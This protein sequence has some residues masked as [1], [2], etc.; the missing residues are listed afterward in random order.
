MNRSAVKTFGENTFASMN[1][2]AGGSNV[3]VEHHY[4]S[5]VSGVEKHFAGGGLVQPTG[6]NNNVVPPGTPTITAQ[7]VHLVPT[8][9]GSSAGPSGSPQGTGSKVPSFSAIAPGGVAKEQV[10]GI[11][12]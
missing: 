7:T 2:A 1:A 11:R 5:G 8:D 4:H 10:L 3:P 6:N 12:R 9:A